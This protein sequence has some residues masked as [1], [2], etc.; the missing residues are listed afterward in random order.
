MENITM[1]YGESASIKAL[2][3]LSSTLLEYLGTYPA[4]IRAE[5]IQTLPKHRYLLLGT[6]ADNRF[7]REKS[8]VLLSH[9]EEY[10][11]ADMG[12]SAIRVHMYRGDTY[13]T[14]R[15]I[16]Y[17]GEELANLDDDADSARHELFDR[18]ALEIMRAINFYGFNT[19]DSNLQ[20]IYFCGGLSQSVPLMAEINST[21]SLNCH[22][23]EDLLPPMDDGR[24]EAQYGAAVGATLQGSGR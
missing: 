21:L 22:P 7:I 3:V 16:E 20:D 1:I 24:L 18:I 13:E 2:E 6:K 9:P 11:I 4:C 17:A 19:P 15:V 10:C 14:S 5:D 8:D 12:H 23:I